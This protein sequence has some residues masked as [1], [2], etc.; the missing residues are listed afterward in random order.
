MLLWGLTDQPVAEPLDAH[1]ARELARTERRPH[2]DLEKRMAAAAYEV[3]HR[4]AC[5]EWNPGQFISGDADSSPTIAEAAKGCFTLLEVKCQTCGH[6]EQVYL[7]DLVWPSD[8][9]IRTLG[10]VPSVCRVA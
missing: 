9:P 2:A 7:P 1:H 6:S 10:K 3:A 4:L 8:K 5:E